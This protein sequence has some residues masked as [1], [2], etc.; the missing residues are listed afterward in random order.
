MNWH[1]VVSKLI[2]TAVLSLVSVL[3]IYV[4]SA[5]SVPTGKRMYTQAIRVVRLD[6]I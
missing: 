6:E 3:V 1:K 2:Q 5:A 4:H